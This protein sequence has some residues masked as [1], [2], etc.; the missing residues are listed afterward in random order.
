MTG[1]LTLEA[2]GSVCEARLEL[3]TGKIANG[4][5][6]KKHYRGRVVISTA[7][8]AVYILL[9]S[10]VEG[11]LSIISFR[12]FHL[13]HRP[14]DCRIA[15]VL[16]NE[17][18]EFHSPTMYRMFLSRM[19]L[20]PEHLPLI[21]PHLKLNTGSIEIQKANF[22]RLMRNE[23]EYAN[24]MNTLTMIPAAETYHWTEDYVLGVAT[25]FLR[26]EDIP[27][28]LTRIRE[29]STN[30]N[31]NKASRRANSH[32]RKLLLSLGYYQD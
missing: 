25:H 10:A 4:A 16:T 18:G 21:L 3:N 12:H 14:L 22:E 27:L 6:V 17:P 19:P 23:P 32:A 26:K 5:P 8:D 24:L 28:F 31:F 9:S 30:S 7:I 29:I 20:K 11:D 1:T 13:P 15:A 2:C